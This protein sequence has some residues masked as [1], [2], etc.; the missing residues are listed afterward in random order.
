MPINSLGGGVKLPSSLGLNRPGGLSS[1]RPAGS[2]GQSKAISSIAQHQGIAHV[3]QSGDK[4]SLYGAGQHAGQDSRVSIGQAIKKPGAVGGL[5]RPGVSTG[6]KP[7][8][9]LIK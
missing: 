7:V 2:I 3:Y 5:S 6:S 4:T 1:A 8:M 9:P